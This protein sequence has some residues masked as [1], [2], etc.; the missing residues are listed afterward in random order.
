M[1]SLTL[2]DHMGGKTLEYKYTKENRYPHLVPAMFRYEEGAIQRA[3]IK[4]TE[5]LGYTSL[6]P[7]QEQAVRTFVLGNDVFVCLPTWSGKSLCYTILPGVYDTLRNSTSSIVVVVSPLIVL[8]KD[9]VR[10]MAD[11]GMRAVFVGD[12]DEEE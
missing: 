3:V 12:C 5:T 2:L 8:M 4:A 6:C 9:Q 7:Q 1:S 11:R 10:A